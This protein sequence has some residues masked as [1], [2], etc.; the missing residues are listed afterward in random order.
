MLL[1]KR[2]KQ[3]RYKVKAWVWGEY[4]V[5]AI[6]LSV[7][8]CHVVISGKFAGN[9]RETEPSI[10]FK[11]LDDMFSQKNNGDRLKPDSLVILDIYEIK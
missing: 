3:I 1:A 8:D 2:L 7:D 11:Q 5:K 10:V 9:V 4:R 6:A